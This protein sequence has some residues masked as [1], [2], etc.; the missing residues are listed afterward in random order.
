MIHL[1]PPSLLD[2]AF[3]EFRF[4]K[5]ILVYFEDWFE[6]YHVIS[7][8]SNQLSLML[9]VPLKSVVF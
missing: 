1:V 3:D 5:L 6:L 4:R 8:W 9:H 7:T 2:L